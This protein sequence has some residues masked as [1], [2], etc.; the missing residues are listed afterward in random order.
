M[1]GNQ[2]T[3]DPR[4]YSK[5]NY[6]DVVELLVPEVY[7]TKDMDL[8][9]TELNP[10]SEVINTN[11][12]AAANIS[13]VLSISAVPGTQTSSI[14][15]I[16]GIAQYFVKQNKLT[17][18][19]PFSFES[20][21]LNPLG[22]S[23]AFYDTSAE[24]HQ[25]LSAT[26]LPKIRLATAYGNGIGIP[27]DQNRELSAYTSSL[28]TPTENVGVIHNYLIDNLGWM[29][30]LNTSAQGALS[31]EPSS[32]VL[33]ALDGLY[34]GK[35]IETVDG[36]K[37]FTE[38][39][40]KNY[41]TCSV[42]NDYGLIPPDF[43]SGIADGITS[44]VD[45]VLPIHT[46]GTQKLEKLQTLIDVIYS[47]LY[48]D[49]Q[50]TRV[51]QALDDYIDAGTQLADRVSKGPFRKFCEVMGL[52]FA[53]L[54][55]QVE[56][57]ERIYDIE[58]VPDDHLQYIAELVGWKLRGADPSSWRHQLRTV[59]DI[60]KQKGTKAGIQAALNNLV[61]DSVFDLSANLKELWES[62]LPFTLLY[63]LGTESPL[64]KDLNTW[65]FRMAQ[66][67]GVFYYDPRSL[68]NSIKAVV[69]SILLECY[70]LFP[71]A[72]IANNKPFEP[73]RFFTIDEYGDASSL[74]TIPNT[75]NEKPY[76]VHLKTSKG[77]QA[78]KQ[79]A[80]NFGEYNEW[81]AAEGW[82]PLGEGVYMVGDSHPDDGS[83][84]TY[85]SGTGKI[86]WV[87]NYRG[88]TNYPLPPFEEIKFY[89]DSTVTA[90]MVEFIVERLK[91][92][93][94]DETFADQVGAFLLAG[95]VTDTTNLGTL[96]EFLMMFSSV[97]VAPN[98]DRVMRNS[99]QYMKNYLPMWNGKS[100]HLLVEYDGDDFDFAKTSMEGNS[101][102]ALFEAARIA[103]EFAPGHTINKVIL[104][105]SAEDYW[106]ASST[107]TNYI[108]F[109]QQENPSVNALAKTAAAQ[110]MC[111]GVAM[112]G[113]FSTGGGDANLGGQGGRG[114]LN[115]FKRDNVDK[116]TD[117]LVSSLDALS[118]AATTARRATRRRNTRLLLPKAGYYDRTGFNPPVSWDGS[119]LEYSLNNSGMGELT[120]GYVVSA[121]QFYPIEDPVSPSGV[122]H[123]CE[124]LESSR[125]FSGMDSSATFPYRGLNV[126][127]ANA[128]YV[129]SS[130]ANYIDRSQTPYVYMTMVAAQEKEAFD[131]AHLQVA[132]NPSD[133]ELSSWKNTVLS[134]ANSAIAS[135]WAGN[136]FDTWANFKFGRDFQYLYRD[137]CKY[138]DTHT[139]G[140]MDLDKTGANIFAQVFGK[141]LFNCGL[142]IQGSAV[143][144]ALSGSFIMSSLDASD[145]NPI[146]WDNG[147]GVFS[148]RAVQQYTDGTQPLCASGTYIASGALDMVV[149][150]VGTFVAPTGATPSSGM[151]EFR[152]GQIL[153]GIEFIQASGAPSGN[154][155]RLFDIPTVV[156]KTDD[157]ITNNT[158]IKC[159][160]AGGLPRIKFDLSSYGD[161]PNTFIKDHKFKL[162]ISAL[163]GDENDSVLGGG[164]MGVWIHTDPI[165]ITHDGVTD[166]Y[167]W[168]WNNDNKWVLVKESRLSR[169]ILPKI[170]K[171]I[172][173]PITQVLED[174]SYCLGNSLH[175]PYGEI[176][177]TS[178][179]NLRRDYLTDVEIEFD[180]RNFTIHN[181]F[182]YL[183]II[184]VP[185]EFFRNPN[186]QELVHDTNT[187][188]YVELFFY[189]P[190]E[191]DKYL[192]ISNIEL[193][194]LTLRDQA[195]VKTNTGIET[196]GIP[197]RPFVKE[198]SYNLNKTD[199]QA[200]LKFYNGLIGQGTGTLYETP[201]ATRNSTISDDFLE[202]SGGSRLNYRVNPE[203]DA[204]TIKLGTGYNQY[205]D[206]MVIN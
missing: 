35:S 43:V 86:D 155:F 71:R 4:K 201:L 127:G 80:R 29:Y 40:W 151:A 3:P 68:E 111:S 132:K 6:V 32:Y 7:K 83:R 110:Y 191:R 105:V 93:Q 195:G 52:S 55:D 124:G 199:L 143:S 198:N 10:V 17:N 31:Y 88:K 48:I 205:T 59:A 160:T 87:F 188:Y 128:K 98:F 57:I 115:T 125:Q 46:S 114:G 30:F 49:E 78:L 97:Q 150:H 173:F 94:V 118:G 76:H 19:T 139:L 1:T 89:R 63:A 166:R 186:G 117:I 183:D 104:N 12:Q 69:D 64:F 18:I 41:A 5:R 184:P 193:Q 67:G 50:D 163:V 9:G 126:L 79:D 73:F 175:V 182:E 56:N 62:Y 2:Y 164:K 92:F 84:P 178:L 190:V 61:V 39:V 121:G 154:E 144:T 185:E 23:M 100:S 34:L 187:K 65:T 165:L 14:G 60:Y 102:Y 81:R 95:A 36:L 181:N 148:T 197:L 170:S 149:P 122:W 161:R 141:G 172:D 116:V 38:F 107:R 168:S 37:G 28:G 15:N 58:N 136:T 176:N 174:Q 206:I 26:L 42:F 189:E 177:D 90:D 146:G 171:T 179:E 196:S 16:T 131:Y 157:W 137:Y 158:L 133:Y 129:P 113:Q 8:S 123:A 72:F 82:G 45:G 169:S 202:Q 112:G 167:F 134:Y 33:S 51:K 180:T 119:T 20:K 70:T 109:P 194:D 192:L 147:S 54:S 153:S 140:S 203:W 101:A 152:N 120:L 103:R 99:S 130:P 96:N 162:N 108:A 11:I 77:Y 138:Y 22:S 200:V 21:I 75:K 24:W 85:L 27:L 156:N 66:D 25:Y 106:E 44:G 135:G 204:R 74:Y 47:P 145:A 53:D 142:D 13:K 91:C 159:K